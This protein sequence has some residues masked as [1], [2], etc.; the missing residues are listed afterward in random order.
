[1]DKSLIEAMQKASEE[2][3]KAAS[4]WIGAMPP[5]MP[6]DMLEMF[7]GKTFNPNG[8]D[9]KTRLLL[10]L[11]ALTV[12]GAQADDQIKTTVRHA[13]EAGATDQEIVETIVQMSLFAG[14]PAMTRAMTLARD[15]M[16]KDGDD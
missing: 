4:S 1:M 3:S 9:A 12:L 11:G 2:W 13:K 15:A 5:T 14:P 16:S 10:T 7:F 6:Q 8:L